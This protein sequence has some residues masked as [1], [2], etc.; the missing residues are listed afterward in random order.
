M[1]HT[2]FFHETASALAG[3]QAVE[4]EL[5]LFITEALNQVQG[6]LRGRLVFKFDGTDY[7]DA[8]LERLIGT[9]KKLC[10]NNELIARLNRFKDERNFLAHKA[11]ASCFTEA[12]ELN[13]WNMAGS[14]ARIKQIEIESVSL[15][16]EI[17]AEHAKLYTIEELPPGAL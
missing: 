3:C 15:L 4:L 13:D 12:Y 10:N 6:Y 17:S 8:S 16:N 14:I 7:D 1:K 11:I 2:E 9:F 5:K